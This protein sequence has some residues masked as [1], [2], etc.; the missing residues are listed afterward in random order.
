MKNHAWI[1]LCAVIM[2]ASIVAKLV[3]ILLDPVRL[4]FAHPLL[5]CL[6]MRGFLY[7]TSLVEAVL[8]AILLAERVSAKSKGVL[9]WWLT[10]GLSCYHALL[11]SRGITDCG[12]FGIY[13][14]RGVNDIL[15][16]VTYAS[17]LLLGAGGITLILRT[18]K[19]DAPKVPIR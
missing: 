8:L 7:G 10:A 1:W 4:G 12:C 19:D 6:S 18:F 9:L 3:S 11:F 15:K 14:L 13:P 17:L 2:T 5:P 16:H